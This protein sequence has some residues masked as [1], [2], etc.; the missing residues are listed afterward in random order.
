MIENTGERKS[1]GVCQKTKRNYWWELKLSQSVAFSRRGVSIY[2]FL[3]LNCHTRLHAQ[4]IVAMIR[5]ICYFK[6]FPI[7]VHPLLIHIFF[8]DLN[9]CVINGWRDEIRDGL[10]KYFVVVEKM[11]GK[12]MEA[13]RHKGILYSLHLIHAIIG[14]NNKFHLLLGHQLNGPNHVMLLLC[15]GWYY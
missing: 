1:I 10:R 15:V 13:K 9:V 5:A 6:Y 12:K 11:K 4:F 7:K 2:C 3:I 14:W 8:F